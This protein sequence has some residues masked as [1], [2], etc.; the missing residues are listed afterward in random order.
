MSLILIS[1]ADD[2]LTVRQLGHFEIA[3]KKCSLKKSKA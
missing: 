3:F 2:V 1:D